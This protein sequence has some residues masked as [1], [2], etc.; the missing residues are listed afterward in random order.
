[1]ALAITSFCRD[2]VTAVTMTT[3]APVDCSE[4]PT[5]NLEQFVPLVE[6]GLNSRSV[7]VYAGA[8]VA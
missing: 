4:S 7:K 6:A 5:R 2:F 3:G 8:V 1:M